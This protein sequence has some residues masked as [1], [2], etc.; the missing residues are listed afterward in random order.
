MD[1]LNLFTLLNKVV[2]SEKQYEDLMNLYNEIKEVEKNL[3]FIKDQLT[4][5]R[6]ESKQKQI[7]EMNEII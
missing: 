7:S 3:T 1:K 4:I 5:Y 6:K 2:N